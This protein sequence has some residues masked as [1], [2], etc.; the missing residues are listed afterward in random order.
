MPDLRFGLGSAGFVFLDALL[1]GTSRDVTK[2]GDIVIAGG[3]LPKLGIVQYQSYELQRV[4][5]QCMV[6]NEVV[7]IDVETLSSPLPSEF[8]IAQSSD[9]FKFL[10]LYS[11]QYHKELGPVVVAE[12]E[13]KI[14]SLADEV[15]DSAWLAIPGEAQLLAPRQ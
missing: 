8:A 2:I 5:Y 12:D 11:P 1:R 13:M 10:V 6:G 4:Y 14:V 9:T 3:D 7:K 15:L